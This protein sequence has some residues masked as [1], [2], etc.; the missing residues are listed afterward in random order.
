MI[1][2]NQV[3]IVKGEFGATVPVIFWTFIFAPND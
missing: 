2:L 1:I 3:I